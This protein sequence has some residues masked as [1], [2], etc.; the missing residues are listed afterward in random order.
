MSYAHIINNTFSQV[1]PLD[2]MGKLINVPSQTLS[3]L[4]TQESFINHTSWT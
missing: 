1:K 3:E 4:S 2:V